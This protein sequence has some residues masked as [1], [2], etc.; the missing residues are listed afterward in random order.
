MVQMKFI[1]SPFHFILTIS[2]DENLDS[3]LLAIVYNYVTYFLVIL[4]LKQSTCRFPHLSSSMTRFCLDTL[5]QKHFPSFF[6]NSFRQIMLT[7]ITRSKISQR[8]TKSFI[9]FMH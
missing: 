3:I 4:S 9:C 5:P 2:I 6:I 1:Q 7:V 8:V